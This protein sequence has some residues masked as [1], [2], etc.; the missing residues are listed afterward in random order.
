MFTIFNYNLNN[1]FIIFQKLELF[2]KKY[3]TNELIKG[4]IFFFGI[5]LVMLFCVIFVEHFLWLNVA[6]RTFLFFILLAVELYLFIRFIAFPIFKILNITKGIS[7]ES[8]SKII[9]NHFEEVKDQ[10]INFLQLSHVSQTT[11]SD[12]ILASIDQKAINL[13]PISFSSAINLKNNKVFLPLLILPILFYLSFLFSGN[14][15]IFSQSLDRVVNFSDSYVKPAPFSFQLLSNNLVTQT[16]TDYILTIKTI[17]SIT[18]QSASIVIGSESYIMEP[19]SL[20]VFEYRFTNP[21]V[22]TQFSI[23]ANDVTSKDYI[24]KVNY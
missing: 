17:G 19:K 15:N 10:L 22:S 21:I 1:Q 12:L 13:K 4:L 3:Y 8:A 6:Q 23:V 18:P 7:V 24:L 14:G 11:H 2:I 16:G 9:G 20:G 5:G